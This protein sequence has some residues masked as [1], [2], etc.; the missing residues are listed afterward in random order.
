[1][2]I[3]YVDVLVGKK[4]TDVVVLE[5]GNKVDAVGNNVWLEEVG[6]SVCISV[7]VEDPVG[8]KVVVLGEQTTFW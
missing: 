3:Y 4:V 1:L 7:V 6:K 5:I 2:P 8:N